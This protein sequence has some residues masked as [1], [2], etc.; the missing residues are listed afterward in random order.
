MTAVPSKP[1][2]GSMTVLSQTTTTLFNGAVPPNG[3]MVQPGP[4]TGVCLVNDN[5]A[6]NGAGIVSNG[7]SIAGFTMLNPQGVGASAGYVTPAGYK[8]MGQVSIWCVTAGYVAA[9][10]W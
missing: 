1:L 7:G 10:G 3:F 2:D 5:G 6:A 9:R 4:E 8:P